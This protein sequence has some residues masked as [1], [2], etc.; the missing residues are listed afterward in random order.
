MLNKPLKVRCVCS[1]YVDPVLEA[2]HALF[3]IPLVPP[4]QYASS[5]LHYRYHICS[6]LFFS[7]SFGHV[8]CVPAYNSQGYVISIAVCVCVFLASLMF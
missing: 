7:F 5:S 8:T 3:L 6:S 1:L 4:N 2:T